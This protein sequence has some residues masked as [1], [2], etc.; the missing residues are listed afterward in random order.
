MTGEFLA[1][2]LSAEALLAGEHVPRPPGPQAVAL[3][4]GKYPFIL[5]EASTA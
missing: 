3:L 4:T 5:H 2:A 1:E